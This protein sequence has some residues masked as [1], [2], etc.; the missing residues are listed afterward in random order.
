MSK[1]DRVLVSLNVFLGISKHKLV[2]IERGYLDHVPLLLHDKKLDY[3]PQPFKFFHSWFN[4]PGFNEFVKDCLLADGY[5]N[6]VAFNDKLKFLKRIDDNSVSDTERQTRL[7]LLQERNEIQGLEAQDLVQKAKI[8]WNIEGDENS[9]FFH[10]MLK[11]RR[12]KQTVQGISLN[13]VWVTEPGIVKNSFKKWYGCKFARQQAAVTTSMSAGQFSKLTVAEATNLDAEFKEE[14]IDFEKAYD[15]VKW[16]Y[17]D[18]LFEVIGFGPNWRD[19]IK[20]SNLFG[21]GVDDLSLDLVIQQVGCSKGMFPFIYLG[22]PIGVNMN[23]LSNCKLLEDRFIKKLSGW[24]VSL[25][26]FGG[27]LTLLKSVLGS[28]GV[29]YFS[30]FKCPEGIIDKLEALRAG[31]FWGSYDNSKKMH[32]VNW[33]QTLASYDKGGLEVGSLWAFNYGLMFKWIWRYKNDP[34]SLWAE[35][36]RAVYG[37]NGGLDGTPIRCKGT[38]YNIVNSFVKIKNKG[39]LPANVLR[40]KVGNGLSISFWNDD[41]LGNGPLRDRFIRL[42]HL[43]SNQNC[44]LAD[45]VDVNGWKWEWKR[46]ISSRNMV[47]LESL[48]TEMGS[49]A[50]TNEADGWKWV[51]YDEENF[52][53]SGTRL[54]ID[55]RLLPAHSFPTKWVKIVPRKINIFLWRVALDRLPTRVN[56]ANRGVDVPNIHC[57][58]CS[59][60]LEDVHHTLFGCEVAASL[61]RMCR[62]W[63]DI[64][65]PY[66]LVGPSFYVGS[67]IGV[68]EGD[69][70]ESLF[71]SGRLVVDYLAVRNSLVFS[72]D[73]MKKPLLFD[74]I[75]N[76]S[77]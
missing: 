6:P 33:E 51:L 32:W 45:R 63:L 65:L 10:G 60:Y 36:I 53:G 28:L 49:I 46:D 67:M 20:K 64:T 38:W 50:L 44:T 41:W 43:D 9:K 14:E 21:V 73:G 15:T 77:F 23:S 24:K 57:P 12:N 70:D 27:R 52:S 69:E 39:M 54:F 34:N 1:I 4:L 76:I 74:F 61:W 25:L 30:L 13:V 35:L 16:D 71:D 66:F 56:L 22:L 8:K 17:L 75:R 3:G 11:N 42:Y 55:D 18:Y 58:I 68:K 47:L 62:I 72:G 7:D 19:W 31:V 37:P 5:K 2:T 48:V 29:Y 59:L 26:S 40:P